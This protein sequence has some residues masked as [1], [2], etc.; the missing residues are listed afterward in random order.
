MRCRNIDGRIRLI[1]IDAPELPGHCNPGRRC[2]PGDGAASRGMLRRLLQARPVRVIPQGRDD[3][4][5]MLARVTV[6]GVDV[7]CRMVAL[8]AAVRRYARIAC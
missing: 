5:R 4:G 6:N 2:S 7:S 1:G 8:G 3:Y